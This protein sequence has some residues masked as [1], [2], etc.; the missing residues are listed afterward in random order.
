MAAQER[1]F[2][3]SAWIFTRPNPWSNANPSSS[4][5]VSALTAVP[6]TRGS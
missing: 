6:Q 3:T 1:T 2:I 4:S 5:F